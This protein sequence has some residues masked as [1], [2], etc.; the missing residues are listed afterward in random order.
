MIKQ[1][2]KDVYYDT[3]DAILNQEF[4]GFEMDYLCLHSLIRRYRPASFLEIGT[5]LGRGTEII[6]NA[7]YKYHFDAKIYSLDLPTHLAHVS[8]QHPINGGHG[9][10]VG[11]LCKLPFIQLRSSSLAFDFS[12][13]PCEGYYVDGEHTELHVRYE[14]TQI[15]KHSKPKIVIYH[16][17]NIPEVLNGILIAIDK[18][19]YE[20]YRVTDTRIS[21]LL[22]K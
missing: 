19:P 10:R 14:T 5:N 22:P 21:Y 1:L 6:C 8:L 18:Q 16:D 11:E 12:E 13:Y 20:L 15:L 9:D 2:S 3:K 4:E 7:V 17:T